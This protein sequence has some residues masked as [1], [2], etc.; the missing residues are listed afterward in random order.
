MSERRIVAQLEV[1]LAGNAKG[2][3]H[4]RKHLGLLD[5]I[6]AQ[7]GFQIEIELQHVARIPGLLRHD[8]QHLLHDGVRG[9]GNN[10]RGRRGRERSE[11]G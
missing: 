1:V 10:G 6:D 5:R 4:H 9:S 11:R 8:G 3:A 2:L 7:I